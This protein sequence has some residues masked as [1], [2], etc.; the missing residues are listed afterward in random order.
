MSIEIV[1]E[2]KVSVVEKDESGN[3]VSSEEIDGDICLQII[4]NAIEQ[5]IQ[6]MI[7][8]EKKG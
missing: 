6:L 3:V 2:G 1:L 5:G 8:K 4:R 7:D